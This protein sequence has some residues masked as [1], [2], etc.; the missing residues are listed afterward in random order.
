MRYD[1]RIFSLGFTDA[2][3]LSDLGTSTL[4]LERE[5]LG[6]SDLVD[7][8]ELLDP[9]GILLVSIG[10]IESST[11]QL[12]CSHQFPSMYTEQDTHSKELS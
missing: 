6:L 7:D 3:L 5:W 1:T 4:E 12:H 10:G 11:S 9:T 8:E 2:G